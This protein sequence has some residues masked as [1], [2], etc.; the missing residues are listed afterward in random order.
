LKPFIPVSRH[1]LSLGK[2]DFISPTFKPISYRRHSCCGTDHNSEIKVLAYIT[3]NFPRLFNYLKSR[4][5]RGHEHNILFYRLLTVLKHLVPHL[6]LPVLV[7]VFNLQNPY[8]LQSRALSSYKRAFS[9][10]IRGWVIPV[11]FASR[12]PALN[13]VH[14]EE[15]GEV[16]LRY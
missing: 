1:K 15:T 5:V 13:Y 6:R 8:Q 2:A 10:K 9:N 16:P 3:S 7:N 11:N 4:A 14:L 12:P